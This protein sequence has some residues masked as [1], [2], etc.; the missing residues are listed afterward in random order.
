MDENE[1]GALAGAAALA[2][3]AVALGVV[4]RLAAADR[5]P[6]NGFAGIRIPSTMR[7]DSAWRAGH[8]AALPLLRLSAVTTAAACLVAAGFAVAH[9]PDA[10]T[11]ALLAGCGV[12][13]A[14]LLA[15]T[16]VAGRAA[17]QAP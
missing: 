7:S 11:A 8:R 15:A 9:H 1:I 2:L 4:A 3:A 17:R 10:A 16:V 6:R 13:L 5:L 14:V 12:L